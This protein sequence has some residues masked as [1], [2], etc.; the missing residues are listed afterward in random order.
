MV[1]TFN[2]ETAHENATSRK[3]MTAEELFCFGESIAADGTSNY[4]FSRRYALAYVYSALTKGGGSAKKE[5]RT[6]RSNKVS[7]SHARTR[8]DIHTVEDVCQSAYLFA[9]KMQLSR[10]V[11]QWTNKIFSGNGP[12]HPID[13]ARLLTRKVTSAACRLALKHHWRRQQRKPLPTGYDQLELIVASKPAAYRDSIER[14]LGNQA[15]TTSKLIWGWLRQGKTKGEARKLLSEHLNKQLSSASFSYYLKKLK[16]HLR[17]TTERMDTV[18]TPEHKV[19]P[20]MSSSSWDVPT[21]L[22]VPEQEARYLRAYEAH[23]GIPSTL[24]SANRKDTVGLPSSR[25]YAAEMTSYLTLPCRGTENRYLQ[26]LKSRAAIRR[27]EQEA[28][29]DRMEQLDYIVR[30]QYLAAIATYRD[31]PFV[32]IIEEEVLVNGRR[33]PVQPKE[34]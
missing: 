22:S 11:R 25:Q 21:G 4:H 18:Y 34:V 12:L 33:M 31:L 26:S 29:A 6:Q 30:Q 23:Y 10:L 1:K 17:L 5:G 2:A 7:S 15:D 28:I 14:E 20:V 3:L 9:H 8:H 24:T 27:A 32:G 19:W 16:N 13:F